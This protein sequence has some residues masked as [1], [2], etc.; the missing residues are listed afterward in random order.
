MC[1][2]STMYESE[3]LTPTSHPAKHNTQTASRGSAVASARLTTLMKKSDKPRTGSWLTITKK[4][5]D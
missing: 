4:V 5:C 2:D 1:N 3:N